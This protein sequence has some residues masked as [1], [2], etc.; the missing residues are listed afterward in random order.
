MDTSKIR[1]NEANYIVYNSKRAYH[2]ILASPRSFLYTHYLMRQFKC[3]LL[4]Y[5]DFFCTS[6]FVS[7]T[8][9]LKVSMRPKSTIEI[10]RDCLARIMNF[11]HSLFTHFYGF[12]LVRHS[13][14]TLNIN[15]V[16][17]FIHKKCCRWKDTT[18]CLDIFFFVKIFI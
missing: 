12:Q 15:H 13:W 3:K 5:F 16:K 7:L 8:S 6:N 1:N 11:V 4:N 14:V 9:W 2:F 10:Y 18:G 17:A